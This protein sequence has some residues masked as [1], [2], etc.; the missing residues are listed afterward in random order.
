M[1][2][3]AISKRVGSAAGDTLFMYDSQLKRLVDELGNAAS[4]K[5]IVSVKAINQSPGRGL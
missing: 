4:A 1:I 2:L 3:T 5:I